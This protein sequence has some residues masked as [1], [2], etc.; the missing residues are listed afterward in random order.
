MGHSH[1]SVSQ[2]RES[3]NIITNKMPIPKQLHERAAALP[4]PVQVAPGRPTLSGGP[5]NAGNGVLSQPVLARTPGYNME[6]E[7]DRVLSK[8]KLDEL[9]R[10]VTG[11]GQGEKEGLAPDVEEVCSILSYYLSLFCPFTSVPHSIIPLQLPS[12]ILLTPTQSVLQVADNFVDQVLQAACKNAKERGSKLLEI[13]DIQLTLERGYNIRIPGYASDEIRTVRKIQP[14]PA[15]IAKMSAVQ[16]S[17]VTGGKG[18][19]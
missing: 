7:G 15:W 18:G 11:G 9:V 17:K 19:D 6:G 16:A 2:P 8:K 14:A 4:M 13:R 5:S 1:P 3:Q 12:P 10:Q